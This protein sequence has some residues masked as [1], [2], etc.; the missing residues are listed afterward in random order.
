MCDNR[1]MSWLE[2]FNYS[3]SEEYLENVLAKM[4]SESV[5]D[6]VKRGRFIQQWKMN[7]AFYESKE[8][9]D[10]MDKLIKKYG[11]KEE[12]KDEEKN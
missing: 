7:K 4:P 6:L 11:N 12:D 9:Q 2:W 10:T 8:G 3:T 5:M 1:E